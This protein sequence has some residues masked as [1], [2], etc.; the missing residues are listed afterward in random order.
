[1]TSMRKRSCLN[2]ERMNRYIILV[3][4]SS[5][6]SGSSSSRFRNIKCK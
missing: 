5:N 2:R 4:D 1:M 3:K 6:A